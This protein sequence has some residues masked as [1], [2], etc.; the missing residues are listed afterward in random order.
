M[1]FGEAVRTG[2]SVVGVIGSRVVTSLEAM[3]DGQVCAWLEDGFIVLS[4][5]TP[6]DSVSLMER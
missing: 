5:R 3:R 6:L 4:A 1:T 2:K